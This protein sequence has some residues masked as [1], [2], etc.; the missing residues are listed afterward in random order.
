MNSMDSMQDLKALVKDICTKGIE[1]A[2]GISP[3]VF[4][5]ITEDLAAAGVEVDLEAT[6]ESRKWPAVVAVFRIGKDKGYAGI[7]NEDTK[8]VLVWNESASK[9]NLS[10]AV[11]AGLNILKA[12]DPSDPTLFVRITAELA[13]AG[14]LIDQDATARAR[15]ESPN[16]V[17]VFSESEVPEDQVYM[18]IMGEAV[19][20]FPYDGQVYAELTPA[21]KIE[22]YFEDPP[23]TSTDLARLRFIERNGERWYDSDDLDRVSAKKTEERQ[24]HREAMR[25]VSLTL[26][27]KFLEL[28]DEVNMAPAAI[29]EGFIADLC[30]LRE[31]PY[32]TNGSDERDHAEQYFD[33]C[34]YRFMARMEREESKREAL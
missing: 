31:A 16:V 28:C 3:A 12:S 15:E 4:N 21:S 27:D 26:P 18:E 2:G 7:S 9:R 20:A 32:I 11:E 13:R 6:T 19:E 5:R 24:A 10:S 1:S 30:N 8:E 34:G 14:L 33:R 25:N 29:L 22:E 17:A 23:L